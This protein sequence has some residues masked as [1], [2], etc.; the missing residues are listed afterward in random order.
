[1]VQLHVLMSAAVAKT[2]VKPLAMIIGYAD[3]ATDPITFADDFAISKLSK[4][5]NLAS[6]S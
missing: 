1:M 2:G 4:H 3:A 6:Q 5:K